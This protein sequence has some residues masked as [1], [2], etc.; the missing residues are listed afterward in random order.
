M[1]I[2]NLHIQHLIV[3]IFPFILVFTF[4]TTMYKHNCLHFYSM[5]V[6]RRLSASVFLSIYL[7]YL[8]EFQLSA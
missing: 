7:T 6:N 8:E 4:S 1:L 2:F 3:N 5:T